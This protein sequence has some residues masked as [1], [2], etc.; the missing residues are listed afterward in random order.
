MWED[1]YDYAGPYRSMERADAALE[2]MF[3][4]GTVCEGERPDIETRLIRR[5]GKRVTR[6]YITL[7]GN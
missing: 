6:F 7:R 4:D 5:E 3:A 1:R 2:H